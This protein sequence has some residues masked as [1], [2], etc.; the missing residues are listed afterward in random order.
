MKVL[1]A[2]IGGAGDIHPFIAV[3]ITLK[4]RGHEVRM[5]MNPYFERRVHHAG[6]EHVPLGAWF[7]L[8]RIEEMP[9]LNHPR[10][11]PALTL[12]EV[13]PAEQAWSFL[14][15][16]NGNSQAAQP[17]WVGAAAPL[18]VCSDDQDPVIQTTKKRARSLRWLGD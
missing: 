13:H 1:I 5:L 18:Q 11:A 14:R 4:T 7:D 16:R 12:E 6:L 10:K 9:E 3:G 2:A 8:K 17:P 15:A